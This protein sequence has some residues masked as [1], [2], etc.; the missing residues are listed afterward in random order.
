M[1]PRSAPP[2][3]RRQRPHAPT[4]AA[5]RG[6]EGPRGLCQHSLLHPGRPVLDHRQRRH[7]THGTWPFDLLWIFV[8]VVDILTTCVCRSRRASGSPTTPAASHRC[9]LAMERLSGESVV[10]F[11]VSVFFGGNSTNA[12]GRVDLLGRDRI[13]TR[14]QLTHVSRVFF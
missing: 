11:L 3:V 10:R 8:H 7:E 13:Q 1:E 4:P 9:L 12:F 6:A 14:T 2:R 5:V